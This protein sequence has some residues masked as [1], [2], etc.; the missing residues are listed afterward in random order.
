MKLLTSTAGWRQ[1]IKDEGG[2]FATD[3]HQPPKRYPCYGYMVL[4]SWGQETLRPVYLYQHDIE[5]MGMELMLMAQ[6]L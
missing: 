2:R 1:W 5:S 4:E 6:K 3:Q